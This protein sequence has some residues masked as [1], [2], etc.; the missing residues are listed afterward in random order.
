MM[1]RRGLVAGIAVAVV[2]ATGGL[3]VGRR[4]GAT[5]TQDG[6]TISASE[7]QLLWGLLQLHEAT[8]SRLS[9]PTPG[10]I[11]MQQPSGHLCRPTQDQSASDA[12]TG[13]SRFGSGEPSA[14]TS[15]L[16]EGPG[17]HRRA[18]TPSGARLVS[19]RE[20]TP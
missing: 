11:P 4:V 1:T 16:G 19:S 9:V 14:S 13:S 12:P 2:A 5:S 8:G 3:L 15:V 18:W 7:A 6:D 20:D 17:A 10:G